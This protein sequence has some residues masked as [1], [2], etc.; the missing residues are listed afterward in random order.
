MFASNQKFT[1]SGEMEYLAKDIAHA[2]Q[3]SGED[4]LFRRK[5]NPCVC[6][7]QITENGLYV[8]GNCGLQKPNPTTT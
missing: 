3:K 6:G 2:M 5:D 8:I 1:V 7:Y 4:R